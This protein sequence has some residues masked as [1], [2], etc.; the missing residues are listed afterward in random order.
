M[1]LSSYLQRANLFLFALVAS[2]AN[3]AGV[4][5]GDEIYQDVQGGKFWAFYSEGIAIIDPESCSIEVT[6]TE[7][8]NGD[9]L[10]T[11]WNDGIYMQSEDNS[12]GYV[13]I[14]S[15]V[16][17]TNDLGDTISHAYVVSTEDRKVIAKPEV[18]PRSVHSYGVYPQNEFWVHSDGNGLFYVINL[19]DLTKTTHDD[20]EAK[21]VEPA[22]GK[23]LWDEGI[24][25]GDRGFATST[26]ET[27]LF[28]ID[29]AKKEQVAAYDFS[30]F[31]GDNCKG[32]HAIAY[33]E[34]NEHVYAECSGKGGAI[35]F[36]VSNGSIQF[37]RQFDAANGA[38][39]ETPDGRF[40]VAS[41]KGDDMLYLFVPNG[42][43]ENSSLE[44]S[45]PM[46]GH[47]SS[48]SFYT[49]DSD[50][51][52]ACS[53]MTENLNR[54]HHR[55]DGTIACGYYEGCTGATSSADVENGVCLHDE[56]NRLMRYTESQTVDESFLSDACSRCSDKGNFVA[57]EDSLLPICI[58]T[59]ECG[60]CDPNPDLSDDGSGYMCVNLNSY[61]AAQ[62]SGAAEVM[63]TLIANTGGMK[64]GNPYG[65][66]AECTFGRTYRAH[67]RGTKY[68]AAISSVPNDALVIIDMDKMEK[69]CSVD[70]PGSPKKVVYAP[71]APVK[72]DAA[73]SSS[74]GSSNSFDS[75]S[76]DGNGI[77]N[78]VSATSTSAADSN[79]KTFMSW[80]MVILVGTMGL[81]NDIA[82]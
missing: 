38:L 80:S 55:D 49:N 64:Q 28:E 37:V 65:Y 78:T 3:T 43:G 33:S 73:G 18:G 48:V 23:L 57:E 76:S 14:G 31:T 58:C 7:D 21:V 13:M 41:S 17:E 62:D 75:S 68:D 32:L 45:V 2:V 19:D 52:I 22:H 34:I 44:Y 15:R 26:G 36:D 39:Y 59:P 27:Y 40:V 51:T 53:P 79:T 1:A 82:I 56:E 30:S 12:K 70:L 81:M 6:I 60:S 42:S 47:P 67:K 10:P 11:A 66:S 24:K 20:I 9:A 35:E 29:L 61:V 8:H 69:K 71:N 74:T 25:L 54:N 4:L 72:L 16:D 46:S 5:Y 50:E 63:P 77:L